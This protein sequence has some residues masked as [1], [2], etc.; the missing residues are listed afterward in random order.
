MRMIAA[1]HMFLTKDSA[2][3]HKISM[4]EVVTIKA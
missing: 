1:A 4:M 2:R 3:A